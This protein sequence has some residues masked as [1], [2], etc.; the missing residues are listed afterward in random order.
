[1]TEQERRRN[2]RRPRALRREIRESKERRAVIKQSRA[3]ISPD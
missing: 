1:V 2:S 3:R